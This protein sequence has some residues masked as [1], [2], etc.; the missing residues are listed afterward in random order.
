MPRMPSKSIDEQIY[1]ARLKIT[2]A[3]EEYQT[4]LYLETMP[5]VNPTYKYCYATSNFNIPAEQQS[6]DAWL[7]AVIKHMATRSKGHGGELT[8]A[9]VISVP[10][11]LTSKDKEFW[12]E[13]ETRKLRKRS[14][15][16]VN[17]AK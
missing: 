2:E 13:Y 16:R 7:R 1:E 15:N 3:T 5:A 4:Q 12:I 9:L 6:I 17:K 11:N 8:K 10:Q 14:A